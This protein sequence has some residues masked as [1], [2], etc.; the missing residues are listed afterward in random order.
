MASCV[1]R[2]CA[3]DEQIHPPLCNHTSY[4]RPSSSSNRITRIPK[5]KVTQDVVLRFRGM[6]NPDT[7]GAAFPVGVCASSLGSLNCRP[8]LNW[9]EYYH[10]YSN[11]YYMCLIFISCS[12]T[13]PASPSSAYRD[14]PQS[15]ELAIPFVDS[16]Y[17][18]RVCY[19]VTEK[20]VFHSFT[21]NK[22]RV[23]YVQTPPTPIP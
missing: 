3:L 6:S 22:L 23:T 12:Q 9:F 7:G 16:Q 5:A 13:T 11:T 15:D 21:L 17:A 2:C 1:I 20:G 19:T 10:Y 14:P 18:T 8:A 4:S